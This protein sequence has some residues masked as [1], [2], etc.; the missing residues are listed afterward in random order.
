MKEW[1]KLFLGSTNVNSI[2]DHVFFDPYAN[3]RDARCP[4]TTGSKLF[5]FFYCNRDKKVPVCNPLKKNL[6]KLIF[7]EV[8]IDVDLMKALF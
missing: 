6:A 3:C 7:L 5:Y 8:F 4:S 2:D 1:I